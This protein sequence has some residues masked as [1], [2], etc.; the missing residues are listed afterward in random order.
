MS[1]QNEQLAQK[2]TALGL[3][4]LIRSW[5][6]YDNLAATHNRLA[7]Q[8]RT[9]RTQWEKQVID[10]LRD[11]NLMNATI[12]ITNGRLTV[13]EEKHAQPLTMKNLETLLHEYFN[14]KPPGS[15]DET[16]DILEYIRKHRTH[17]LETKLK[18]N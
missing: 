15:D 10:H 5:V 17:T 3:P 4:Q 14:T 18:K 11:N 8:A 13:H 7:Q 16:S 6:H 12:Q 1:E 9:A 2:V